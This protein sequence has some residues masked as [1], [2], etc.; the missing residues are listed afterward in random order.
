[1]FAF[2]QRHTYFV[3]IEWHWWGRYV[4]VHSISML[5]D[6][7][8]NDV[9]GKRNIFFQN[10]RSKIEI[11]RPTRDNIG[12]H[13]LYKPIVKHDLRSLGIRYS[14]VVLLYMLIDSNHYY[15]ANETNSMH[16]RCDVRIYYY[17]ILCV[18]VIETKDWHWIL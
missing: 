9:R 14:A 8:S 5:K 15:A 13:V 2:A 6:P 1:M 16:G 7:K 18:C 17:V 3:F 10:T 11:W 4:N 12:I